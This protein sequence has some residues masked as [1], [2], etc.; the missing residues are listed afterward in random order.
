MNFDVIIKKLSKLFQKKIKNRFK[1]SEDT[2]LSES[3]RTV[4]VGD[5]STPLAISKTGVNIEGNLT[6]N[7][8]DV[9]TGTGGGA[10]E[11]NELSDVTYSSGDLTITSLDTIVASGLTLDI[12]GDIILDANSGVTKF[13]LAG[14]TD[15][16]CTLTVEANG[17][18]TIATADSDGTN[19]NLV[20]QPDGELVF[21]VK[22]GRISFYDSDNLADNVRFDI[23]ADGGLQ[24]S[25]IDNALSG[26]DFQVDADGDIILDS[27][28]GKFE[29]KKAGTE[30]SSA[31]SAY[32]GMIL[33]YTC[34]LND[35]ADSS[36]GLTTSYVVADATHKITFTAPP[37]GNVEIF[38]SVYLVSTTT[39]QVYFGLSDNATY[40][41]I[42]VTHEHKV[43]TGDETDQETVNHQW[44]IT[45]LT[46]GSSYTYFLGSKAAQAGRIT[47]YWGGDAADEYAPFIMKATAL[48]AT[49]YA[50]T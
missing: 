28:N 34:L 29:A 18:T 3:L 48:P 7:G 47:M 37:S 8:S 11:L 12:G 42:D 17:Q 32:A 38:V 40:N 44:V 13:Y 41:T 14:D 2:P 25:T 21:N 31:G 16:L 30:F 10:T 1:F 20:L 24:I 50:G 26:A 49:I 27:H 33:G 4:K 22:N 43:W 19:G 36:Y 39:R 9:Q 5:D 45:G 6:V 46:A 35:A 23:S 15:D